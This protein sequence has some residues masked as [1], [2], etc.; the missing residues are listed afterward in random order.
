MTNNK[1]KMKHLVKFTRHWRGCFKITLSDVELRYIFH[2]EEALD[3]FIDKI[4]ERVYNELFGYWLE[5]QSELNFGS[6][7]EE[8]IDKQTE[9]RKEFPYPWWNDIPKGNMTIASLVKQ[10]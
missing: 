4:I 1:R 7:I 10:T 6:L 9:Q 8:M 2:D 3:K 5:K